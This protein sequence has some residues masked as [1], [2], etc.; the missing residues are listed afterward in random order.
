MFKPKLCQHGLIVFR[1]A[2]NVVHAEGKPRA[3]TYLP[4]VSYPAFEDIEI[5]ADKRLVIR[6][7]RF[8][9]NVSVFID[10]IAVFVEIKPTF[11]VA[12]NRCLLYTSQIQSERK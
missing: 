9:E 8:F 12:V 7:V 5:I 11:A 1:N 2:V 3:N 4:A 10:G 6:V